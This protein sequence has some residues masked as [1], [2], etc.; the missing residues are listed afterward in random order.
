[1]QK[2][3]TN[4]EERRSPVLNFVKFQRQAHYR[5]LRCACSLCQK[6][7]SL[8]LP[9]KKQFTG[10]FCSAE[11][12]HEFFRNKLLFFINST[13]SIDI[14]VR[15]MRVICKIVF[16]HN[17]IISVTVS[18]YTECMTGLVQDNRIY[19]SICAHLI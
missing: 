13:Q 1:M 8:Y 10:L 17:V 19:L 4:S 14:S 2:V 5:S 7:R 18:A 9:L 12:Y 3:F 11:F 6:I 15:E 16:V